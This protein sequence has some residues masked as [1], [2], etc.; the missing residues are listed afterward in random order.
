[1][2][3]VEHS[4]LH[5][6]LGLLAQKQQQQQLGRQRMHQLMHPSQRLSDPQHLR[7]AS[8]QLHAKWQRLVR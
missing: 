4:P 2:L 1:V 6:L 7:T 3:M 8:L 5:R